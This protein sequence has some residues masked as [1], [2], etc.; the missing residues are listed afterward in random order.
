MHDIFISYAKADYE[1]AN[2]IADALSQEGFETWWD[3]S[4]PTGSTFDQAIEYAV[5]NAKCVIVLWS[6][7]SSK[8]EWVHVEAAE[9]KARNILVPILVSET[10][11]PF[12]FRR[13]Q[14]ADL[15]PW[16]KDRNHPSFERVL[17]DIRRLCDAPKEPVKNNNQKTEQS[18]PSPGPEQPS[19]QKQ[20]AH[21]EPEKKF[22][23]Y[24]KIAGLLLLIALTAF[25]VKNFVLQS[26][27]QIGD[28]YE[29]GIVF[30]IAADGSSLKV[31]G[32]DDIGSY[33]W[34]EAKDMAAEYKAGGYSDW[35]LPTK[36]ELNTMLINLSNEGLGDFKDDWY[37]SST[38]TDGKGWEQKFPE[39]FQ[40]NNGVG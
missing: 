8:S 29:N 36:E 34:Y 23:K 21:P 12:A 27:I 4:I 2:I 18:L 25:A 11:I 22:S 10:E 16:L 38:A 40:Q 39:G 30:E 33:N 19:V 26:E 1:I 17:D 14:T 6:E 28:A 32:N 3:V 9:G 7:N 24:M 35:R 37:W 15:R 20:V 5:V 31:C 13:R